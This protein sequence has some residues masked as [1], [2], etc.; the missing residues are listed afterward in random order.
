MTGAIGAGMYDTAML[1]RLVRETDADVVM[2][3]GQYTLLKQNALD[4]L[5]PTP[6]GGWGGGRHALTGRGA[7]LG[8][9]S[10]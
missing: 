6:G 5:L 4:D 8:Y 2:L 7:G 1:T 10:R 9:W 3:S